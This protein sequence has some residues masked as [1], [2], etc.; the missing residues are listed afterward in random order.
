[1]INHP[2]EA[3]RALESYHL[4][5]GLKL[6]FRKGLQAELDYLENELKYQ[7]VKLQR[8]ELEREAALA[9]QA[10]TAQKLQ[11][12]FAQVTQVASRLQ[13]FQKS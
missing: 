10:E 11:Q 13:A 1:M 5:V 12:L 8:I 7:T 9:A 3:A 2:L 4:M 6:S